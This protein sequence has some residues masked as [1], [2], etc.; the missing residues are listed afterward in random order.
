MTEIYPPKKL[1]STFGL[2]PDSLG[3]RSEYKGNEL[4]I[5]TKSWGALEQPWTQEETIIA[6]L[7]YTWVTRWELN[8][9]YLITTIFN[10]TNELVGI[11]CDICSPIQREGISFTCYDW[12]MD[13]WKEANKLPSM[14][15]EDELA[16][17]LQNNYLTLKEAQQ[18]KATAL[19]LVD[20]LKKQT[21]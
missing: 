11:Y 8:K 2:G 17:A 19:F 13:I 15:D 18:A 9:P 10:Q 7:G 5:T 21:K 4:I 3:N 6:Q 14:L 1:N 12:Y 16:V 20:L